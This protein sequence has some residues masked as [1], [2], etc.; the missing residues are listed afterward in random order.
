MKKTL[1]MLLLCM[2]YMKIASAEIT[3]KYDHTM[4]TFD[5][6]SSTNFK[7]DDDM[8]L[9]FRFNKDYKLDRGDN[10]I[11]YSLLINFNQSDKTKIMKSYEFFKDG[12][13]YYLEGDTKM[14]NGAFF[15]ITDPG[16]GRSNNNFDVTM[17]ES[18]SGR[19]SVT[20]ERRVFNYGGS[21]YTTY[22]NEMSYYRKYKMKKLEL[23]FYDDLMIAIKD[24]REIIIQIPYAKNLNDVDKIEYIT[25]KI[26][27]ETL[28][29][30]SKVASFDLKSELKQFSL[31]GK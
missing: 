16:T 23:A 7:Y 2:V 17:Q 10:D 22:N 13:L 19:Y 5:I 6:I 26:S 9:S 8:D 21:F 15:S 11:T 28:S 25:F 31:Q 27:K 29:E 3:R 1:I 18:S 4:R 14:R 20:S 30:W 12:F 24:N